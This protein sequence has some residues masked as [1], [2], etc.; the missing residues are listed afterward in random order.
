MIE[1]YGNWPSPISVENVAA[2]GV[3]LSAPKA[4][5]EIVYWI[6]G[7]PSEKGRSVIVQYK[8]GKTDDAFGK[9]FDARSKVHEYGGGAYLVHGD[10]LF[11]CNYKDQRLYWLK[12]GKPEP[13]TP[14]NGVRYADMIFDEKRGLLY[15]IIE[16]HKGND[17]I[18]S[19][20]KINPDTKKTEVI[21]EGA[22]FYSNP[23]LS[24]N[25]YQLAYLRWNH[26]NMPWDGCE[27]VVHDVTRDGDLQEGIVIAGGKSESIF[28]PQFSPDGVLYFV[29]DKSGYWNLYRYV[30]G[31]V[32][33]LLPMDAEFGGAQFVFGLS[34]YAFVSNNGSYDIVASYTKEGLDYLGYLSLKKFTF[35]LIDLP[36]TSI[37][38]VVADEKAV[39][40]LGAS[41]F[42]APQIVKL[43]LES[44]D[45]HVLKKSREIKIEEGMISVGQTISFPT[46]D[47]KKAYGVFYPPQNASVQ[48][49]PNERPP[50]LVRCHGGPTSYV[51]NALNVDIQFWTSRGFGVLDVNY[52]GS[53]GFGRKYREE[54]NGNWGK[55]DV[56]DCCDGALYLAHQGLID[57]NRMAIK[58]GSAGGYTS[59][60]AVAFRDVFQGAVSYCGISDLEK[61]TMEGEKFESHYHESLVGPYPQMKKVYKE[62]SPV[63]FVEYVHVPVLLL[64]G[65]EDKIVFPSQSEEFYVR[66]LEKNKPATYLLFEKEGH[67]FRSAEAIHRAMDAEIKFYSEI[68][69]V[70][71]K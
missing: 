14:D 66:M 27:L 33:A 43:D 51:T 62:R 20:V 18:N 67:G 15:S 68:F 3:S 58:G 34:N 1:S 42:L 29:S 19:L 50:L 5:Q 37:K 31:K 41:P 35:T 30:N 2:G 52:R 70:T 39:Y 25:G 11:F 7:R 47:G 46:M 26:P 59:L 56:N 36:Y 57:H 44:R 24:P 65:K 48:G 63:H 13:I 55:I 45:V 69:H 38:Y 54:L 16:E 12:E 17:V 8:D 71:P 10:E 28:Q 4:Y 40:F 22:D 21:A 9:E 64:H 53:V 49:P 61:M 60:A 23:T 6:E 32:E